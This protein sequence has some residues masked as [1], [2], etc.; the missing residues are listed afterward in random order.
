MEK[1]KLKNK[2]EHKIINGYNDIHNYFSIL[3]VLTIKKIIFCK[4]Q[5]NKAFKLKKNKIIK[6]T[7]TVVLM[8]EK[9]NNVILRTSFVLEFSH[10]F[11][12]L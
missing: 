10:L 2:D 1:G 11:G 5:T 6:S 8:N 4:F 9:H 12:N 3:F 7:N